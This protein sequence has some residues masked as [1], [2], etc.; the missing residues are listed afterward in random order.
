LLKQWSNTYPI[1]Q[2]G[3]LFWYGDRLVIVD[4]TSLKRGVISLYHDLPTAGHPGIS[5]TTWAIAQDY[6]WPA[7]KKDITEYIKGCSTCQSRKN[8]P[9]K[10]KPPLF[11]ISSDTYRTP[12][13]SIAM[14]FIVKLP[15][16]NT[17]D[18]I[19]TITRDAMVWSGLVWRP[20]SPNPKPEPGPV[21]AL[22]PNREPIW[23]LVWFMSGSGPFSRWTWS[24]PKPQIAGGFEHKA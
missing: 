14:D 7:L 17:Y 5:N 13:T 1:K 4:N 9:N 3:Q 2:E 18:T 19:L 6:W 24:E 10:P 20:F 8:Q 21:R 11:P 16:S 23:G 22:R 12:F 15:I